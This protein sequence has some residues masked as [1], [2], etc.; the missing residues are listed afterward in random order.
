MKKSADELSEAKRLGWLTALAEVMRP[1]GST[2][3][4]ALATRAV[5]SACCKRR[6]RDLPPLEAPEDARMRKV[7]VSGS[8]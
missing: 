3:K 5:A 2:L 1:E 8:T 4:S 7:P 6:R